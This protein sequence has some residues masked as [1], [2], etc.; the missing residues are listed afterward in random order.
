MLQNAAYVK[1]KE[2]TVF[3]SEYRF[4]SQGNKNI[5]MPHGIFFNHNK[6]K[7]FYALRNNKRNVGPSVRSW[8]ESLAT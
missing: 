1:L 8:I 6:K 4:Y 2:K 3:P 7:S 5:G